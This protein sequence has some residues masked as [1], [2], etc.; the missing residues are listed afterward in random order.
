[1]QQLA[2]QEI[3]AT[4]AW[5]LSFDRQHDGWV[6][7]GDR[8]LI[9]TEIST[10]DSLSSELTFLNPKRSPYLSLISNTIKSSHGE[11]TS[12]NDNDVEVHGILIKSLSGTA[13]ISFEYEVNFPADKASE[14][15]ILNQ[16]SVSFGSHKVDSNITDIR[17]RGQ[18]P[19]TKSLLANKYALLG[20]LSLIILLL[21]NLRFASKNNSIASA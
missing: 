12:I 16:A 7:S 15:S 2:S 3:Y 6:D 5:E 4:Q 10:Y 13:V 18:N 1:M 19:V 20:I 17:V 8:V 11:I 9:T 21:V 14:I